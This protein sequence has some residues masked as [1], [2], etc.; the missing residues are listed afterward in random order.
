MGKHT[1]YAYVE[2][3][4]L[5]SVAEPVMKRLSGLV[6]ARDWISGEACAVNQKRDDGWELGMNLELPDP[7]AEPDG[8]FSDIEEVAIVCSDLARAHGLTFMIGISDQSTKVGEDLFQ[9]DGGMIDIEKLQSI[10]GVKP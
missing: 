5:A 10:I 6:D 1:L 3:F 8:W 9:I 2:G 7:Y 4:D